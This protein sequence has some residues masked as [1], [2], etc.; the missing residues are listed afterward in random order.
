MLRNNWHSNLQFSVL[1]FLK[2]IAPIWA[3]S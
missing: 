2:D 3:F 1:S